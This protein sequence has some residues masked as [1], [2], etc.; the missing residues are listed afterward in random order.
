MVVVNLSNSSWILSIYKFES[1][2]FCKSI[3]FYFKCFESLLL[4]ACTFS[5]YVFLVN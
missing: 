1:I 4:N 3:S 2:S 5:Y